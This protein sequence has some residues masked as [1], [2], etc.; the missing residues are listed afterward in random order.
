[1]ISIDI[2]RRVV[3]AY[4]TRRCQTYEDTAETFDIGVATVSRL[5]R[6]YRE[7]G[8][9]KPKAVGGNNPKKVDLGWLVSHAEQYP[10]DRLGDR[11]EAWERASGKRVSKTTM[12]NAMKEIGWT[13]K[14]RPPSPMNKTGKTLSQNERRL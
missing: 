5:L 7:T 3:R 2:R 9:V 6:L 13:H 1:M 4:E 14:K 10:D 12:A 11:V 8:D